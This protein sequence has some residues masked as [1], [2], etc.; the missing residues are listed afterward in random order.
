MKTTLLRWCVFSVVSFA[1]TH[2]MAQ[3]AGDA[4]GFP[5]PGEPQVIHLDDHTKLTL[6]GT[7]YGRHHMAPG[8]ENLRTANWIYTAP[9]T[10]VVWVKEEHDPGNQPNYELLVSDR[11]NTGCVS[12]EAD[13]GSHVVDG[14]DI[15]GFRLLAFPRW[16]RETILRAE[17]YR[18]TPSQEQF[19][20]TNPVPGTLVDWTPEPL[21]ATKSAGD[22]EVTLTRLI[23]GAPVPYREGSSRAP[24]NDPA[25]QCVHLDFSFRVN[26]QPTTNWQAWPVQTTDAA[27]NWSRGLIYSY[28]KNGINPSYPDRIHPTFPPESDGYYYQPGLWAD[29]AEWK[30]RLEFIQRFNFSDDETV[31]FTNLPVKTGSQQD[32]DEEWTWEAGNTNFPCIVEATVNGVHLR[33][34]PLLLVS[35]ANSPGQKRIGVIIGADPPFN[36]KGMNLTVVDA[37]DDQGREMWSPFGVPWAGHYSLDLPNVHDDVKTLDLKLALHKSRFVEFTVKP[38]R[39]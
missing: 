12:I 19:V 37:T 17:P 20:I 22:L 34:L 33:L 10:T 31:T 5:A 4:V 29:E 28:P 16:D 38:G 14:V 36:P 25:N 13:T 6:L 7:S 27:G 1:I 24:T 32:A 26:G 15:Q 35:D 8:Y 39:P 23:A 30:V 3:R 21:P 2:A 18:G 11:A 9:D